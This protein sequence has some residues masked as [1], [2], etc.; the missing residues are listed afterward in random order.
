MK[1]VK[2]LHRQA[3]EKT[4]LALAAKLKGDS[5]QASILFKEAY[6]LEAQAANLLATD[7]SAEP[8][9]SVLFRS[10]ASL[11]LDCNYLPEAEKLV[12]TALL[13]EPPFEIAEEL[14]DLLE[15]VYFMRHL[16]MRGISLHEDEVQMSI[17]GKAVGYGIAPTDAFLDRV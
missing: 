16:E 2:T 10:A 7:F 17:A 14:R 1:E 13:G 4:D 8:T 3:M 12:C 6:Q 9:R 5:E 11:A 15:Q